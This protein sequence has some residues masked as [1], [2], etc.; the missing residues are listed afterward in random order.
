MTWYDTYWGG[1]KSLINAT[2]PEVLPAALALDVSAERRDWINLLNSGQLVPPW[3]IVKLE[4]TDTDWSPD[5][6]CFQVVA[7]I[8]YI[9][10]TS[11]GAAQ[12]PPTT[13]TE[14]LTNKVIA[15]YR[16]AFGADN[17]GTVLTSAPLTA[18]SD[19]PVNL[20]LLDAKIPFQSA[21]AQITSII[22]DAGE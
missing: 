21:A 19:D 8:H 15:L 18:N 11:A 12:T 17:L 22:V 1:V 6:Q 2:W 9:A 16:A 5:H 4:I 13:A 10:Q 20:V 14:Y 7:T 3:V